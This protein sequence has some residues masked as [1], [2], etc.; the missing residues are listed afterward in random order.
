MIQIRLCTLER[1]EFTSDLY[2][3]GVISLAR[4]VWGSLG[5]GLA[6]M[7]MTFLSQICAIPILLPP[8]AATCF[9]N[10]T[11]VYLRVARPR[12]IVVGHFVSAVAAALVIY[13]FDFFST[14]L[15]GGNM[16]VGKLGLALIL[17][18]I[19]MQIFDA[20][21][22]PAAATAVIPILQ[23]TS[24]DLWALPLHMSWGAIIAV[25]FALA[26]NRVWFAYP[27]PECSGAPMCLG[28]HQEKMEVIGLGICVTGAIVMG[29]HLVIPACYHTGLWITCI[30]TV[31][32]MLQH[33]AHA[34]IIFLKDKP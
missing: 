25:V 18:T 31:I 9:I 27:V 13:G 29:L 10:T 23:P 24:T 19:F 7:I 1:K 33:F 2:R 22:P 34:Q 5:S 14:C 32:L 28:L 16:L 11:C 20:D 8:L 17:C 21:H 15:P 6:F 3:P 30:G 4:L 26:W 12:Q